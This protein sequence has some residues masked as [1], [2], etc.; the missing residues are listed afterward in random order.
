MLTV[1]IIAHLA[2]QRQVRMHTQPACKGCQNS[3]P[4]WTRQIQAIPT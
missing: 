4:F 2:C 3:G 1:I